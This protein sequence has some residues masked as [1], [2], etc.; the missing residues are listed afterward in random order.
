VLAGDQIGTLNTPTSFIN[1]TLNFPNVFFANPTYSA[2]PNTTL[3][4]IGVGQLK[5]R[6]RI[7]DWGS[8]IGDA[9]APWDDIPNLGSVSNS[10]PIAPGGSAGQNNI[11]GTWS[12]SQTDRCKFVGNNGQTDPYVG[13]VLG[14]FVP[15]DLNCNTGWTKALH[16][17]IQVTLSA[18]GID[19]INDSA[20]RNMDFAK[21]SSFDQEAQINIAGLPSLG[22]ANRDVYLFIE[23]QH[24]PSFPTIV[25][26]TPAPPSVPAPPPGGQPPPVPQPT[27]GGE[28]RPSARVAVPAPPPPP[29]LAQLAASLPT[30]IVHAYHD[31]GKTQTVKGVTYAVLEP[32]SSFGYFVQHTGLLFGWQAAIAGATQIAPDFYKLSVPEGGRTIIK[33]QINVIDLTTWWIWLIVLVIVLIIVLIVWGVRRLVHA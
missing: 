26:G 12:L 24:M 18:A 7:A 9:N 30:Y 3:P 14:T 1:P 6:F 25:N 16:Q 13:G 2:D 11:N 17:C 21:A 28:A 20:A 27:P 23:K 33:T 29:G 22:T 31:T 8:V 4:T 19:F 15:G 10:Q 5:A 32:Q